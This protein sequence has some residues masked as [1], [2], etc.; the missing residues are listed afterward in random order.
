MFN[1]QLQTTSQLN[2]THS[3]AM[4][5]VYAYERKANIALNQGC[6]FNMQNIWQE[7]G[8]PCTPGLGCCQLTQL[9]GADT[10]FNGSEIWVQFM[11]VQIVL[12]YFAN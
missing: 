4:S 3:Y 9:N 8:N 12:V 10:R 5:S 2:V 11:G 6:T 7:L 1:I